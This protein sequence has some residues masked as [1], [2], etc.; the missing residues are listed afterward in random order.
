MRKLPGQLFHNNI[1]HLL[2]KFP[3]ILGDSPPSVQAFER[4]FGGTGSEHDVPDELRVM[5]AGD[6][7][8][9][10]ANFSANGKPTGHTLRVFGTKATLDVDYVAQTIT[11]A[12]GPKMPSAIGR[13][14]VPFGQGWQFYREG[15]RNVVRFVRS[16]YHFNAGLRCLFERFYDSIL[17]DTPP[18]IPYTEILWVAA[19]MEE[20]FGQTRAAS[21]R[22]RAC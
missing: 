10:F 16:E 14:L 6:R 12:A 17:N 15:M 8:T 1:D 5:L 18:P 3:A 19:V 2:N 22:T 4:C 13:L 20:I 11:F 9:G 7:V 21:A